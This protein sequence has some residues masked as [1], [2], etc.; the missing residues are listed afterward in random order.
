MALKR[1]AI[2]GSGDL[3][4]QIAWHAASDNH[5]DV[6]GF[7]DD[8]A[9]KGS[10][11]HGIPVLGKTENIPTAFTQ[12]EFDEL[13]LA[14]GYKHFA[15]RMRLFNVF[16]DVVPFGRLIHTSAYIDPSVFVG[17]GV[18]VYPGC[19]VDM[20]SRIEDNV[21]LNAGVVVAHDTVI[22]AHSFLSPAVKV[23]GFVRVGNCVSLGI[24]TAVVD[25]LLIEDGVRT[26]AGAVV[27]DNLTQPG[28]YVGVPA[29][30]KKP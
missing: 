8:F 17:R 11:R 20:K 3:G 19:V 26:G 24:G 28:L 15:Q 2:I 22:G 23:A 18:V 27:I 4:E 16:K 13:L 30:Y 10:I 12:G 14:I 21:L 29:R 25:N 7:F 1:L 9:E 6:V 5:Y